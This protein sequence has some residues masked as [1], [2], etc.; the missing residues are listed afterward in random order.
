MIEHIFSIASWQANGFTHDSSKKALEII[1]QEKICPL[2]DLF[3]LNSLSE[4]VN[5]VVQKMILLE[6][7]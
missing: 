3:V 1:L 7:N 6:G 5:N 4:F 2:F